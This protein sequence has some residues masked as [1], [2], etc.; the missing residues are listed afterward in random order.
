VALFVRGVL[1]ARW[2]PVDVFGVYAFANSIVAMFDII[3]E[4]GM[5]GAFLHRAPETQDEGHTA[6]VHFTLRLLITLIFV[7]LLV[8]GVFIFTGGLM[9]T[10]LLVLVATAAVGQLLQ[11]PLRIL[12]RRVVHRRLALI[13]LGDA[14]LGTLLVLSLAWRGATLWALLASG[15]FGVAFKFLALYVW[16]PVW[17]PQLVWAPPVMRYFLAFGS[18]NV[19]ASFLYRALDRVDDLWVGSYLGKTSLGFYS[20]AYNFATYPRK[21]L[22]IPVNSVAGGTYAELKTDRLRLSQAFFRVNAVLIRSGFFLGGLLSLIAP[23]F[24]RLVLGAK[25]M[26]MLDAFRL[27][28]VFTLFDPIKTTI[29]HLFVAVGKPEYLVK[30]RLAQFVAMAIGLYLLGTFLGIAGVALAVDIM[31]VFGIGLLLLYARK[32]VD[33]SIPRLFLTPFLA[34]TVGMTLARGALF[35]P[36]VLGS[37][38]RTAGIKFVIFVAVYVGMFVLLERRQIQMMASSL[39]GILVPG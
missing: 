30:I 2:L 16:K 36:G 28:L 7:A 6:A 24:I 1:L 14:V 27:M 32:Y 23:E 25:W 33:I 12:T 37:D 34:L 20:K 29:G 38:W 13:Q 26:P 35:I 39:K 4:F 5:A 19:L 17:R 18:R 9:Q 21:L 31:L 3:A 8:P 22:A 10:A 15:I 11:T